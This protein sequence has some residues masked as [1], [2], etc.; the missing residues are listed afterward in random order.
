MKG[1][2][3]S[4]KGWSMLVPQLNAR[5][6]ILII[7]SKNSD[8]GPSVPKFCKIFKSLVAASQSRITGLAIQDPDTFWWSHVHDS[9]LK[10]DGMHT[11][12]EWEA[13]V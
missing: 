11:L 9:H 13:I 2:I 6:C 5:W 7:E 10:V 8:F 12:H 1:T 4:D 3:G